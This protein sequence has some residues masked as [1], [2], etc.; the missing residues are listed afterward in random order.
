[1]RNDERA[2]RPRLVL[3]RCNEQARPQSKPTEP[4]EDVE[5]MFGYPSV[6]MSGGRRTRRSM[7]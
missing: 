3:I 6:A 5:R 7:L 1:M 2:P 4:S